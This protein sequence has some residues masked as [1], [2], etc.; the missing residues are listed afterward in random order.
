MN[1]QKILNSSLFPF[2]CAFIRLFGLKKRTHNGGK[3]ILDKSNLFRKTR[4][5]VDGKGS[6]VIIGP[7]CRFKN[8]IIEIHGKD[9]FVQLEDG[10]VVY[11]SCYISIKGDNCKCIIGRKTT[12][13][14]ASLFM[15][16]DDTNIVMREDCMLGRRITISTTDFHSIIDNCTKKR[17]NLAKDVSIGNHVWIGT[18]V[19][20]SKGAVIGNDCVVGE[21]A[22]VTKVFEK[23]NLCL[24]GIPANVIKENINWAREKL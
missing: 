11:E 16:E 2:V 13:G 9:S 8:T 23:N 24:A 14:S 15:E 10:V 18:D 12:I 1:K 4:I 6:S 21:R 5:F 22:L 7:R 19:S 3:I 20:I 17:I